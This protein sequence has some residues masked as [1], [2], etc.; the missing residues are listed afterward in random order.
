M[1][2]NWNFGNGHLNGV[3]SS[4]STYQTC[5]HDLTTIDEPTIAIN[6]QDYAN[7]YHT[8]TD[9]YTVYLL[10]RFFQHEPKSVRI[11]FL[12]AHPTTNLELLWSTLFHSYSRLGQMN[13]S[14]AFFRE[15]IW[16]PAQWKSEI[17]IKQNRRT[18][19]SFFAD[20]RGHVLQEFHADSQVNRTWPCDTLNV[21]FLLRKNYVAHPRNP[22]GRVARQL[23][24]EN[25]VIEHL[26]KKFGENPSIRFS[27]GHFEQLSLDEQLQII[28]RTDVLV[29]IHGA[30][31][32]HALFMQSNRSLVE[33]APPTWQSQVHFELF[34]AMNRLNYHR[35]LLH[36]GLPSTAQTIYECIQHKVEQM[37]PPTRRTDTGPSLLTSRT[38]DTSQ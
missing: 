20:F 38:I 1:E 11:L 7:L 31:L 35:C 17:D 30:G 14:T 33:L 12:D 24:N 13:S 9:L 27:A 10:C 26:K 21:Y 5:P 22:T 6:R 34:A 3:F 23:A 4:L 8:I 16:S 32:T 29:G 15:L 2:S 25:Q 36:D 18:A 28:S 19:P 37:C